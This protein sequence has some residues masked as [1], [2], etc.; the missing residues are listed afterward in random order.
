MTPNFH[1]F[2][3]NILRHGFGA[4]F[5]L[6]ALAKLH[7]NKTL[8]YFSFIL[9]F[10]SHKS[11]AIAIIAFLPKMTVRNTLAIGIFASLAL[12]SFFYLPWFI[13]IFSYIN[14]GFYAGASHKY[15]Y[16]LAHFFM[17]FTLIYFRSWFVG[18]GLEYGSHIGY[19]YSSYRVMVFMSVVSL[20]L[21]FLSINMHYRFFGHFL[22]LFLISLGIRVSLTKKMDYFILVLLLIIILFPVVIFNPSVSNIYI[23]SL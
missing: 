10:F 23:G 2:M 13:K 7:K 8:S 20:T 4:F 19:L 11:T 16:F 12:L 3:G 6:I 9:G 22:F 5:L 1:F 17:L 15:V 21:A 14:Q 18:Y